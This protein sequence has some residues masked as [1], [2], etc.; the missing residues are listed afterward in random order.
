MATYK[1]IF[2][3]L[4]V[5][6][7]EEEARLIQGLQKRFSLSQERAE[8]IIHRVPIVIKK[9]ISKPE[10]ERYAKAF[11]EIG[12]RI[13]VEEEPTPESVESSREPGPASKPV[14]PQQTEP[15]P[16]REPP[17]KPTPPP[18]L[19]LCSKGSLILETW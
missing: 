16:R 11:E 8:Q 15:P 17:P 14:P 12:G 4:A 2:L 10:M 19:A 6:G 1:V 9:G 3:G 18:S 13:R 5:A 7:P